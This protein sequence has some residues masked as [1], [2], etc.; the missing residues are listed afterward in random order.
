MAGSELSFV[1]EAVAGSLAGI[2]A[3]QK[4]SQRSDLTR[5]GLFVGGANL[6]V[7]WA[8]GLIAGA[9]PLALMVDGI[10]GILNGLLAAVLAIGLLPFVETAFGITTPVRLLELAN[11]NHPLLKRL[12]FE[13]DRGGRIITVSWWVI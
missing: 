7:A 3:V 12:L 10:A 6:C 4:V 5:A 11:P 1:I 8:L 13:T 2:L 9:K